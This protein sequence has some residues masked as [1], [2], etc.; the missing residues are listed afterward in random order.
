MRRERAREA[1][2]AA[3]VALRAWAGPALVLRRRADPAPL[4]RDCDSRDGRGVP[5]Q[6]PQARAVARAPQAQRAVLAPGHE[7]GEVHGGEGGDGAV[8]AGEGALLGHL[9]HAPQPHGAVGAAWAGGGREGR[10][11]EGERSRV[12]EPKNKS[13]AHVP[14]LRSDTAKAAQRGSPHARFFPPPHR[15]LLGLHPILPRSA[16]RLCAL[17]KSRR[18]RL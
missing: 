2:L 18:F 17:G 16:R 15:R 5:R 6:H 9:R 1:W 14:R 8:V 7:A 12:R 13:P 11:G 4:R 10:G 3:P